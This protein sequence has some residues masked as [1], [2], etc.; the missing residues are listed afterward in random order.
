MSGHSKWATTKRHKAAIDAKRGKI[1]SR[2][3]KELTLAAREGGGDA[4]MSPRLRT[5]LL[6]AR[7]ANM[8]ADN[9]D[10]AIKKGTGEL[11]GTVYEELIY[12]GYGPG[13]VAVLVEVTTDN[14]NRSASDV[15]S[16]FTKNHGNLAG[17]GALA[18]QFQRM[19]Q[20]VISGEK[21]TE[22]EL[23]EYAVEAGAEDIKTASDHFE[24][25]CPVSAYYSVSQALEQKGIEPDSSELAY[26]PGTLVPVS[27]PDVVKQI[28]RLID[29]LEDCEDVQNV[30]ANYDIDEALLEKAG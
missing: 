24:V 15:R 6:K 5:V 4:A 3:S 7:G 1:F 10:R 20:F 19:G 28:L 29:Q 8:P 17:P 30:Y 12:E 16:T 2:I 9:I 11:P 26:I 27:D 25:L 14:K 22:E 23:M 13:G 18:F 21:T